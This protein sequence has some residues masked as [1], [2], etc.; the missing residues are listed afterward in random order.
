MKIGATVAVLLV[1]L[2][3]MGFQCIN[4][5]FLISVNLEGLTGTF[6]INAGTG[7]FDNSVIITPSDYLDPSYTTY[8]GVRIYDIK[9]STIGTYGG[10]VNGTATVNGTP[11]LTFNGSFQYFNTPRSLLTDANITRN[12]AG[13]NALVNAINS[14]Q[15]VTLRGFGDATP[16]PFPAGQQVVI[17]VL[18]QVDAQP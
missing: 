6:T 14:R 16:G 5:S 18:G 1:V 4:D 12:A 9:V 17:E 13:L 10:N 15:Q 3:T 2:A 7:H 8:T 11:V